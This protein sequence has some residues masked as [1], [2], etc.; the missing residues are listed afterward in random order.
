MADAWQ[1]P[2]A[3]FRLLATV[4]A[5]ALMIGTTI[6][7]LAPML[8]N[9]HTY[10]FHDWDVETAFRYITPLSIK[11]YGQAPWWHPWLCGGYPAW[12]H[13]E[14]AT[15]F[16]SP[17]LPIYLLFN[18]RTGIRLEVLG[19][20]LVGL[21][22]TYLLAR[23]FTRSIALSS[24]LAILYVLN[25]RWALQAAVGHTWHLKYG[26]VPWVFLF[27]DRAQEPGR[28]RNA[29]YAGAVLAGMVY[30]GAIYPLPQTALALGIYAVLLAIF[31]RRLRPIA[32]VAVAGATSLGLSAP[33]LFAVFD[34]LE[35]APRLIES[36]ETIGLK[37]LIVMLT[38]H[39]QSYSS[40]PIRVPAYGW[41]EWGIYIGVAGVV[42]LVLGVLFARGP[43]EHAFKIIG[44][45]YV[46]MGLGSFNKHAPWPLL[47]KLPL[48]ASQHVPS[49]F[50]Y[51]AVLLLGL[52]F[53]A[54]FARFL[55]PRIRY[56]AWIDLLLLIPVVYFAVDL[57]T[58]SHRPFAQA[59]W[60]EKPEHIARADIFEQHE[61][62]ATQ[63]VRRDW[64]PPILLSMFANKGV[65]KC[66]GLD[67]N[68]HGIGA[69][70]KESP[71]YKGRAY[72]EEGK[73]TAKVTSWSPNRV[74]V[75]VKDATPGALVVY[76]MNFNP[77]WRANGKPALDYDHAV[78]ARVSAGGSSTIV[79]SY[80]P[81]TLKLSIPIF[82]FTLCCVIGI[83]L[84]WRRRQKKRAGAPEPRGSYGLAGAGGSDAELAGAAAPTPGAAADVPGAGTDEPA[85]AD[86]PAGGADA[87]GAGAAGGA[88][89]GAG[90]APGGGE[91]G[92]P[93]GAKPGGGYT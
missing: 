3:G 21:C 4:L 92:G 55:D 60:M 17:Y 66:Y 29:T 73:G 93:G 34:A 81:R 45:L 77:S 28:F 46:L 6:G 51:P 83:P 74:T 14:G 69:I 59:F 67:P 41:H 32:T 68:F 80:F 13:F 31:S 89:P 12:G 82:L 47:H 84:W 72:V 15:N 62:P 26:W 56:H 8:A 49:R 9:W 38:D 40:R 1:Q 88:E 52:C 22:G 20:A 7:I 36:T 18:V 86:E 57:A 30:L 27:F 91:S 25:G 44:L 33:K 76:N 39:S 75:E 90:G 35:R 79:F 19:G 2:G 53:V 50:L 16:I 11:K 54:W 64:A 87:G 10:G 5:V 23:R 48:F 61:N 58:V 70:A 78:A 43:R 65:I 71:D 37:E 42:A 85:G 24:F 63:Y